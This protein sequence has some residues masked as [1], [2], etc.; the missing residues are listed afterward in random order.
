MVT[1]LSPLRSG[2]KLSA[3]PVNFVVAAQ[4]LLEHGAFFV[5]SNWPSHSLAPEVEPFTDYPPGYALYL[6]PFLALFKEPYLA[7]TV[8]HALA[9]SC[10]F[11]GLGF[12]ARTLRWNILLRIALYLAATVFATFQIIQAAYLTEPLF[13]ACTVSL[14]ACTLRIV[15]NGEARLWWWAAAFAFVASSLKIIGVFNLIWF[16]VP[17]MRTSDRRTRNSIVSVVACWLPVLLWFARNQLM[18]GQISFSHLLGAVELKYT[19][20]CPIHFFMDQAARIAEP[21]WPSLLVLLIVLLFMAAPLVLAKGSVRQ[22]LSGPQATLCAAFAM[23]FFG[24]WIVSLV[25]YFS[26]LD[27]RL[28]SPSIMLGMVATLNGINEVSRRVMR[29]ARLPLFLAPYLFLA[30]AWHTATPPSPLAHRTFTIPAEAEAFQRIRRS[31]I[32][33]GASHFYSDRDYRLQ[34]YARIPQRII[35]DTAVVATGEGLEQ[36]LRTGTRPYFLMHVD[37]PEHEALQRGIATSG[38]LLDRTF[39]QASGLVLYTSPATP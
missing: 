5:Y 25:A 26:H 14:A 2:V 11:L 39:D 35:W 34:L 13:I 17:V 16:V 32:I 20:L 10:F 29:S 8:A 12:L 38:L 23:H 21:W 37:S 33:D 7:A 27:D 30:L 3:D 36:L 18:Y 6:I 15:R 28:L 9:V 1:A 24:I 19:L 4:N 22:R 31:G